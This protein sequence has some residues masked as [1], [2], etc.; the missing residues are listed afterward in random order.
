MSRNTNVKLLYQVI[1]IPIYQNRMYG[2]YKEAIASPKGDMRLV[3]DLETG[4]VYNYAFKPEL[5]AYDS[6]YQNEQAVSPSFQQHLNEVAQIIE[7]NIGK[8]DFIEVGCGKGTFLEMLLDRGFDINGFDPTYE[9]DNPLILNCYF[10]KGMGI[11]AKGIVMRHVLEHIQNPVDFL[12]SIRDANGGAGLI[13]IEVPCFNWILKN[14]AWFDIF[15][16]H[17]NYFR[18]SD[19]YRI[20]GNVIESGNLFGGQYL[21]IIA[22]LSSLRVPTIDP[23]DRVNFPSDFL[24]KLYKHDETD[25]VEAAIWGGASKGVIFSLLRSR[26]GQSIETVIDINPAKQCKYIAGSGVRVQSPDEA[27]SKLPVGSVIY[28]MNSNYLKEIMEMSNNS[29]KYVCVDNG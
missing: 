12:M 19:F 17:V 15:Y 18:V 22:D 28:V 10:E 16:E 2:S 26:A 11:A 23:Q 25:Q 9:G 29:Y 1:D 7:K 3:E 14:M 8:D 21:Y 24:V 20:F 13:Y 27:L 4:L 5:I 6:N